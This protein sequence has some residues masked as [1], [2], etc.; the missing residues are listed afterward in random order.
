MAQDSPERLLQAFDFAAEMAAL[1]RQ[2]E[3]Q[4][5]M[6]LIALLDVMDSF[7]RFTA[8]VSTCEQPT[9][10]QA[11]NWSQSWLRIGKQLKLA[12]QG[13]GVTPMDCLGQ[14]ADPELH[15]IVEVARTTEASEGVVIEEVVRGYH[16]HG[17]PLRLPR[18]IVA[19]PFENPIP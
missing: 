5:R 18:V 12:L 8:V 15:E 14:P 1:E 17:R 7:D 3:N 6:L 13:A 9:P 16:W 10:E 2:Y 11:V 4:V 19:S